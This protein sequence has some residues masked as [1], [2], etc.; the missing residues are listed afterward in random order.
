MKP[1]M[2]NGPF[3]SAKPCVQSEK[4]RKL[5]ARLSKL[6]SASKAV[7]KASNGSDESKMDEAVGQLRKA[8]K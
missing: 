4:I 1:I 2:I 3:V 8:L 5:N 6:E 7:L